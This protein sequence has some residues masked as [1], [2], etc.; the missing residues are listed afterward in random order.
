MDEPGSPLRVIALLAVLALLLGCSR[1][2][3][4]VDP[5]FVKTP[6]PNQGAPMTP[7]PIP[8]S[9]SVAQSPPFDRRDTGDLWTWL[10]RLS[11]IAT[12]IALP[13]GAYQVHV[14]RRELTRRPKIVVGFGNDLTAGS[15]DAELH[16]DPDVATFLAHLVVR[17]DGSRTARDVRLRLAPEYGLTI[18]ALGVVRL[19][20]ATDEWEYMVADALHPKARVS[21]GIA[22][23]PGVHDRW[24]GLTVRVS[25]AD[26][27]PEEHHL[28][29]GYFAPS[30]RSEATADLRKGVRRSSPDRYRGTS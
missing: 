17:N 26:A 9:E 14:L 30:R 21:R 2:I 12:L 22:F 23:E 27:E 20:A 29:I 10:E 1:L 8:V 25:H 19:D 18:P 7:P 3:P 6:I 11:W 16:Y 5:R 24:Y 4:D 28:L 13:F 15:L